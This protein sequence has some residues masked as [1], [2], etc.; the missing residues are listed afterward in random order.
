MFLVTELDG[1]ESDEVKKFLIFEM[2]S[3]IIVAQDS[4]RSVT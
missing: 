2:K 3:E 4:F 1:D